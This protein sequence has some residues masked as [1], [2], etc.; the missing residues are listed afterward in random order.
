MTEAEFTERLEGIIRDATHT[1]DSGQMEEAA[2]HARR[3][4][5][6][7]CVVFE[8]LVGRPPQ[9]WQYPGYRGDPEPI[10]F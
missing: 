9:R 8:Y 1:Y 2:A 4:M 7:L 10:S 3:A 6:G 5:Q